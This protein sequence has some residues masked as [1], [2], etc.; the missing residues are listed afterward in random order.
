[1]S[2]WSWGCSEQALLTGGEQHALAEA[3]GERGLL[4]TLSCLSAVFLPA[5]EA[6]NILLRWRRASSYL[7]EEF[8]QGN[9]ERECYEEICNREEA[10]EVFENDA[11]TV[12]KPSGLPGSGRHSCLGIS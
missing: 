9:L 7:L 4:L 6:N 10:R 11:S 1:M 3:L 5:S 2:G 8:L 12:R